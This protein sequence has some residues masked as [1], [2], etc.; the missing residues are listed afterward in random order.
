MTLT[1]EIMRK[2]DSYWFSW[3]AINLTLFGARYRLGNFRRYRTAS[4]CLANR[5]KDSTYVTR[6]QCFCA[7]EPQLTPAE[8]KKMIFECRCIDNHND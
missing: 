5:R 4:G 3:L 1:S 6:V 8:L 7:R 2:T